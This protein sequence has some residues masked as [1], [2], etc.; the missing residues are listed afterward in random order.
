MFTG[1]TVG[2]RYDQLIR[3]GVDLFLPS[4]SPNQFDPAAMRH[5]IDRMVPLDLNCIYY[6]H[7]GMTNNPDCSPSSSSRLAR[8]FHGRSGRSHG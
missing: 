6:G 5:A 3:D 4:T 7:F 1:D 2:I 8:Y